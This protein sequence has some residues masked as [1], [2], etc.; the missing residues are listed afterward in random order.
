MKNTIEAIFSFSNDFKHNFLKE[1]N[2]RSSFNKDLGLIKSKLTDSRI[3]ILTKNL[4]KYMQFSDFLLTNTIQNYFED[5]AV[6][7]IS[8][9][10]IQ[11]PRRFNRLNDLKKLATYENSG[12]YLPTKIYSTSSH[13]NHKNSKYLLKFIDLRNYCIGIVK[14]LYAIK[15]IRESRIFKYI[16]KEKQDYDLLNTIRQE[17]IP[18]SLNDLFS[19]ENILDTVHPETVEAM[20]SFRNSIMDQ[21]STWNEKRIFLNEVIHADVDSIG[22]KNLKTVVKIICDIKVV[23]QGKTNSTTKEMDSCFNC[24]LEISKHDGSWKISSFSYSKY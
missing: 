8:N 7:L 16:Q 18:N 10:F 12:I 1:L 4:Y 9:E 24:A 3:G 5:R 11:A 23:L 22:I 2:L 21:R 20:K 14:N 13:Q 6:S 15:L 17:L 19:F